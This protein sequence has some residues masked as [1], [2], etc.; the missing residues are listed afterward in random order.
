MINVGVI[1]LGMMGQTHLDVYAKRRDVKIVAVSDRDKDRLHGKQKAAGNIEGQAQ[2]GVDLSSVKKYEEGL[3]LIADPDVQLVDICLPTPL[4]RAYA[5]AALKA[6]KHLLVEKPLARTSEEAHAIADAA[7]EAAGVA[8][9]AMCMRFWPGWDWLKRAVDEGTYGKVL[10]AHFRRVASHPGGPFYSDGDAC[11]GAVLDLHIHDA[12]FVQHLFGMPEAVFSRGYSR[13]T[14]RLDHVTTHYLYPDGP[15]VVAE[16]GWAMSKGF[17]F[18][19]Q[20]TVNFERATA[21]F[22]IGEKHPLKLVRDGKAEPVD[23]PAGMGYEHEIDYLIRCIAGGK[24]PERVTLRDAARSVEIVE[25]EVKSAA[26]G[27]IAA[28]AQPATATR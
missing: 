3:D 20:F 26:T 15:M 4:H 24:R 14:N 6:G 23:L 13:V 27:H 18:S 1:G 17:G 28:V 10:S 25:A 2:G 7:E 8:M 5:E 9:P 11:G 12:D 16:G 21:V 19:M 22:D